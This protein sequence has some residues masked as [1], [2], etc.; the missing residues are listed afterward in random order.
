VNVSQENAQH[1]LHE[2]I[3]VEYAVNSDRYTLFIGVTFATFRS[4]IT[5]HS[6]L[7]LLTAS[8]A[9]A[10]PRCFYKLKKKPILPFSDTF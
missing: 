4:P 10:R 5:W 8:Y 7:S 6:M 1:S 3:F 2:I 9:K